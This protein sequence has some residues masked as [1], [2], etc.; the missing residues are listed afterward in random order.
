MR[1]HPTDDPKA[2]KGLIKK[3][4]VKSDLVHC[5][6][7]YDVFPW[8]SAARVLLHN[9]CTTSLEAGFCGTQV[10]TYAPSNTSLL[11]E[12]DVNKL[13]PIAKTYDEA[14]TLISQSEN[15]DKNISS[16]KSKVENWGLV[17]LMVVH[18][19]FFWL[20]VP[21]W[22]GINLYSV[23]FKLMHGVQHSYPDFTK[24]WMKWHWDHHMS[25]PNENF[26]VVAPWCDYLFGTRKNR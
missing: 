24:K 2:I 22:V 25:N 6:N 4:G 20:S 11:K 5:I 12:D 9:C 14:L 21:F 3:H 23:L 19:P 13:F 16:F 18:L 26:G 10:I 8:I 17:A 1:P 7:S 15:F